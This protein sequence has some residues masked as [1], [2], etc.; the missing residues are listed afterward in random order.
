MAHRDPKNGSRQ[1]NFH[2]SI[3]HLFLCFILQRYIYNIKGKK[4]KVVPV[5]N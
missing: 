4:G 2:L 1:K 5:L 3:W